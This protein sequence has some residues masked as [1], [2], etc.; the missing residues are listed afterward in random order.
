MVCEVEELFLTPG[1]HNIIVDLTNPVL[2]S[3]CS[4]EYVIYWEH[5]LS[6]SN[7]SRSVSCNE[8]YYEIIGLDACVEYVVTVTTMNETNE[9]MPLAT[10]NT[11]TETVGNYHTEIILLYL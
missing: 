9:I 4:S 3:S 7:D 10:G 6:G 8:D 2:N 1:S 5:A 11:T